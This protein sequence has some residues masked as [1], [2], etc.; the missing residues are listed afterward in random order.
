MCSRHRRGLQGLASA[1]NAPP[2]SVEQHGLYGFAVLGDGYIQTIG[3]RR[4][5]LRLRVATIKPLRPRLI[6]ITIKVVR[7]IMG[8]MVLR[9]RFDSSS[10]HQTDGSSPSQSQRIGMTGE[11]FDSA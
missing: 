11:R 6:S 10:V 4:M 3:A 7:G 9:L 5:G 8:G 2:S 1:T